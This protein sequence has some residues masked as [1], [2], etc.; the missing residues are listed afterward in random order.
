MGGVERAV[1]GRPF[2]SPPALNEASPRPRPGGRTGGTGTLLPA[3][4]AHVQMER[5][6]NIKSIRSKYQSIYP[7]CRSNG[8]SGTTCIAMCRRPNGVEGLVFR[9]MLEQGCDEAGDECTHV[10]QRAVSTG[11]S[12]VYATALLLCVLRA[13]ASSTSARRGERRVEREM[14]APRARAHTPLGPTNSKCL[15]WNGLSAP[16]AKRG[17]LDSCSRCW[18]RRRTS[19]ME[20]TADSALVSTPMASSMRPASSSCVASISAAG[21]FA[22]G[23]DGRVVRRTALGFSVRGERDGRNKG[24]RAW[25]VRT[26]SAVSLPAGGW[27]R[28]LCSLSCI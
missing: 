21:T 2:S 5:G 13:L 9:C 14:A 8:P 16:G 28:S 12:R 25:R 19:C 20:G 15:A 10:R 23:G 17:L 18:I 11:R 22:H 6:L 24:V 26:S 27:K 1:A 4:A 3:D 7:R